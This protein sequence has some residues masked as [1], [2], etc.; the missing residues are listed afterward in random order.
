MIVG[1]AYSCRAD[2]GLVESVYNALLDAG[3]TP[4]W[5][6]LDNWVDR[7]FSLEK[8]YDAVLCP[9]DRKEVVS[10]ALRCLY[11]NIPV[12]AMDQGET[13]SGSSYD[14]TGRWVLTR[15]ASIIFTNTD[16]GKQNVIRS[17]EEPWRV[18]T[19]GFTFMDDV[20]LLSKEEIVKKYEIPEEYSIVIYNPDVYSKTRT[21]NDLDMI[22][23]IVDGQNY[24][25]I[26]MPNP[27]INDRMVIERFKKIADAGNV[28]IMDKFDTRNEFLSALK[29]CK[30]FI[31]N[32]S[33]LLCELPYFGV[34]GIHIG[35]RN[36]GRKPRNV[37]NSE[38]GAS[39]RIARII[40]EI[41]SYRGFCTKEQLLRKKVVL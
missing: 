7:T 26:L 31:G 34:E 6:E 20:K 18:H 17:G 9:C 11:K 30:R 27:D 39:V 24:S 5:I 32:S 35:E 23:Y 41:L 22:S 36:K 1:V 15:I 16:E 8:E 12:F 2:K 29:Y 19:V 38:L 28:R 25:I 21:E 40:K 33:V 3:I 4:E 10:F 13:E 14:N 37:N